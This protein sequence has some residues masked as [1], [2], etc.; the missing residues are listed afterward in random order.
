MRGIVARLVRRFHVPDEEHV[1]RVRR[2]LAKFDRWRWGPVLLYGSALIGSVGVS[3]AWIVLFRSS[4]FPRPGLA[5][6]GFLIGA[7][8]GM[9]L[10]FLMINAAHGLLDALLGFRNERLMIAYHD[11]LEALR[12]DRNAGPST[13][14]RR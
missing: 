11:A 1:E 2:T 3:V 13:P 12:H 8:V 7:S 10:G 6:M 9:T 5:A 14:A 4:L